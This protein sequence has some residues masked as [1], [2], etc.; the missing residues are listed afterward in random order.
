MTAATWTIAAWSP[1]GD[2]PAAALADGVI[3]AAAATPADA[4]GGADLVVLAGA[5]LALPG[6]DR[7]AGAGRW[8]AA[9]GPDA[10][11]T[12]VAST[13]EAIVAA[14]P[15][16]PACGSSAAIRWPAAR[17]PATTPPTP[18]LFVG[19]P[20]VVVPGAGARAAAIGSGSRPWPRPAVPDRSR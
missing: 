1:S 19:R 6:A 12:D 13:K 14:R 4:V 10:V 15:T 20:W 3:D 11:V 7:R 18:D 2:G 16:P 5:A 9:L 8:P 17:R